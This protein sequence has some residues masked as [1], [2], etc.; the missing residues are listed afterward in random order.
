MR[1]TTNGDRVNVSEIDQLTA[2]NSRSLQAELRS[3]LPSHVR[4]IDVDLSRTNLVD[5][6]GIGA[7][8]ALRNSALS[9]NPELSIRLFNAKPIAQRVF[10]LIE[11]HR[12]FG[13][14]LASCE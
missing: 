10:K 4:Q 6:C 1:I 11:A 8:V 2:A 3:A 14:G 12:L 5:C 7:L 9:Q 13:L